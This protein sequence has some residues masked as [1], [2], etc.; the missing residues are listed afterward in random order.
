MLIIGATTGAFVA[1]VFIAARFAHDPGDVLGFF[2]GATGAGLAV[3]GALWIE[4]RKKEDKRESYRQMLTQALT[5][6]ALCAF[7]FSHDDSA[8]VASGLLTF[9]Q[10]VHTFEMVRK[11]INI[12]DA[13]AYFSM[14]S[15]I[16]WLDVI[17]AQAKEL[18]VRAEKGELSTAQVRAAIGPRMGVVAPSIITTFGAHPYWQQANADLQG[19]LS[20][21]GASDEIVGA[22]PTT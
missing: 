6:V 20:L 19:V 10:A 9:R 11:N 5:Q 3:V 2:G 15:V 18:L 7:K 1:C 4:E 12:D 22:V 13:L 16:Y 17:D 21:A 14:S 8:D